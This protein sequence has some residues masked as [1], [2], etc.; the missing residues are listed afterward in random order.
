MIIGDQDRAFLEQIDF[1]S[2]SAAWRESKDIVA[3]LSLVT[4]FQYAERLSDGQAAQATSQRVDWKYALHLPLAYPG[5]APSALC[6]FRQ[7]VAGFPAS[8]SILQELIE[9]CAELGLAMDGPHSLPD[10]F[11]LVEVNCLKNCLDLEINLMLPAI[12]VLA[13]E[14][15]VWLK[16]VS[17]PHWVS[18]YTAPHRSLFQAFSRE[19]LLEM[20]FSLERD[21]DHLVKAIRSHPEW[22]L[23]QYP[24]IRPLLVS[25][26]EE[27]LSNHRSSVAAS[28]HHFRLDCSTCIYPQ[29]AHLYS[30]VLI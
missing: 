28:A 17:L 12:E 13:A 9:R 15:P 29:Q 16:E 14:H 7:W 27:K 25:W 26:K 1:T 11:D 2:L 4:L 30:E 20:I 3:L 6:M 21:I 24:E 23:P 18:R 10:P 5:L 8:E 19:E 22:N